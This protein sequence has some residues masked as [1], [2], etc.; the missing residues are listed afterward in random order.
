MVIK[1]VKLP[2]SLDARL[3]RAAHAK[4]RSYS[5]VMREAITRG[6]EA[7]NGLDMTEA[8]K[9]FIGAA[10]GPGDLSTNKSHFRDIGRQRA[11]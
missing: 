7:D 10:T 3:R 8:L 6:L 4:K 1:S 2:R 11:R 9:G 5:A